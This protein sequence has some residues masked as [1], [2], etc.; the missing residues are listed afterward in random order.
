VLDDGQE[1]EVLLVRLQGLPP[2]YQVLHLRQELQ[3]RLQV[4]NKVL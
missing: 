3:L 2:R 4:S 1:Q